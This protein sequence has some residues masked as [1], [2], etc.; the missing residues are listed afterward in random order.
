MRMTK[1][2]QLPSYATHISLSNVTILSFDSLIN[3]IIGVHGIIGTTSIAATALKKKAEKDEEKLKILKE[4]ALKEKA[5]KVQAATLRK[6]TASKKRSSTCSSSSS[7]SGRRGSNGLKRTKCDGINNNQESV[8][9]IND[10]VAVGH[11]VGDCSI[12][13]GE[14]TSST[15]ETETSLVEEMVV[16][17]DSDDDLWDDCYHQG[18]SP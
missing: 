1:Q 12:T 7:S 8:I 18:M 4:K 9:V 6:A 3:G 14:P 5:I 11:S 13:I 10:T 2:K 17:V 16:V 15:L